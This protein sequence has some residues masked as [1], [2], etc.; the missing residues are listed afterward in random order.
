MQFSPKCP[1]KII[2]YQSV[3]NLYQLVKYS[4]KQPEL[5]LCCE[6]RHPG[7]EHETSDSW[8]STAN[9][10]FTNR[11]RRDCWKTSETTETACCSLS[12]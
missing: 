12:Y 7:C 3:Q 8:S 6:R 9:R 4:D 2:V 11:K 10:N 1:E 5:D